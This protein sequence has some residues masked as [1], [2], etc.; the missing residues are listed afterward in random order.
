MYGYNSVRD[1]LENITGEGGGFLLAKSGHPP[2][3]GLAKSECP[4]PR[5]DNIWIKDMLLKPSICVQWPYLIFF[6]FF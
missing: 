2:P 3:T 1:C 5:I 4:P 6:C